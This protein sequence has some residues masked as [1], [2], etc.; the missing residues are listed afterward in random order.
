M[1]GGA[2]CPAIGVAGVQLKAELEDGAPLGD[3]GRV[4]PRAGVLPDP[5]RSAS[6]GLVRAGPSFADR[7]SHTPIAA[8]APNG[9]RATSGRV[10]SPVPPP[11]APPTRVG[12]SCFLTIL[13]C[14]ASLCPTTA[15]S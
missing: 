6:R 2:A 10:P 1:K 9:N 13:V 4:L 8:A 3:R 12:V 7:P 11:S 5:L 15:A 14:A